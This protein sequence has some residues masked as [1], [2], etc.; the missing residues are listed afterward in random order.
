MD[1]KEDREIKEKI[2][3]LKEQRKALILSHN[4]QLGEVQDIADFVG[5]S[6]DLSQKA[7]Q[8]NAKV[9]VFCGVHFM[10][11]TAS[12]LCPDKVVL[13]PDENAGCPMAEMATAADLR[14][15]KK[16]SPEASVVCYINSTAEVKAESDICCTSSNALKVVATLPEEKP[17][18]FVPDRYLGSYVSTKSRRKVI[19]WPGYCPTHLRITEK[20]ILKLKEHHPE[21]KVIVHPECRSEVVALADEVLGTG[22]MLRFVRGS[23]AKAFI[24]GTEIGIIYRM[25]KENP[26]KQFIPASDQAICPDMKLISLEKILW[27]LEE[28]AFQVRVA[29][30]LRDAAREAVEKMLRIR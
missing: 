13:L 21:A 22:G 14:E 27:S 19:L 15:K 30:E 11:E 6:L 1:K 23:R 2:L 16:Y 20:D 12:L 28:M 3:R 4:Y 29:D 7:S 8:T 5:D 25:R 18:L 24:I 17:I 10:A 26:S 9:I